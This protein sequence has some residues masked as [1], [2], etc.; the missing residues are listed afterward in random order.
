ML[1][2]IPLRDVLVDPKAPVDLSALAPERALD[3][4]G[5]CYS[6]LPGPPA[7][8]VQAETARITVPGELQPSAAKEAA[9]LHD[10]ATKH[11][12]HGDYP[13]AINLLNKVL[14]LNPGHVEA[15]RNLGM[16]HF[17]SGRIEP[18]KT[19]LVRALRLDPRDT[20][21]WLLLGNIFSKVEDDWTTA[22]RCYKRAIEVGKP[23]AHVL[24]SLGALYAE[25]QRPQEAK[26]AFT[27]AIAIN[28]SYP[29]AYL[30]LA[31]VQERSG[32]PHAALETRTPLWRPWTPCS[33]P[34]SQRTAAACRSTAKPGRSTPR[35]ARQ[36]ASATVRR[37]WPLSTRC[38]RA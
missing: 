17:E 20:W 31:M 8:V 26:D 32:D 4:L 28:N 10:R 1:F 34:L 38:G 22:E 14:S 2:E 35:C 29:N 27:R 13:R 6:F 37:R 23:D 36:K 19:E 12:Q 24:T 7:V 9:R 33:L 11:A 30:G 21:S 18:A 3:L 5:E 15:R 25:T 16:A